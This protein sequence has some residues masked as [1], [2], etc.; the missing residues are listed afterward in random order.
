MDVF[1]NSNSV[2]SLT[3]GI[4]QEF[5]PPPP[6]PSG[7]YSSNVQICFPSENFTVPNGSFFRASIKYFGLRLADYMTTAKFGVSPSERPYK[8]P[9][10]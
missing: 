4:F 2:I 9:R 8:N 7:I 10:N 1:R 6:H 3:R 5:C